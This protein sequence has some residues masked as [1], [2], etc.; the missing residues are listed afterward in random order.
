MTLTSQKDFASA[1]DI[2]EIT[3]F[4]ASRKTTPTILE[5]QAI[6]SQYLLTSCPLYPFGRV[7]LFGNRKIGCERG[8][9]SPPARAVRIVLEAEARFCSKAGAAAS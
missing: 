7:C 2:N 4:L 9:R 1:S 3:N 5:L 8:E 6:Y